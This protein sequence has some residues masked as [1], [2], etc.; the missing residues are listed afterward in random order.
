[1]PSLEVR[2]FGS[3]PTIGGARVGSCTLANLGLQVRPS[4]LKRFEVLA[5]LSNLSDAAYADPGGAEHRQ[6]VLA[7]D[8][9]TAWLSV[10][11]RF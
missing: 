1:V 6:D 4:S 5:K 9:R 7:Q 10:R 2:Y 8:G 11:Y 3:R